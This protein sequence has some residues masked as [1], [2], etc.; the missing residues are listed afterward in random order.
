MLNGKETLFPKV[1]RTATLIGSKFD[2]TVARTGKK[3]G[4]AMNRVT[5]ESRRETRRK[6]GTKLPVQ[7]DTNR[8]KFKITD[9]EGAKHRQRSS[10][11]LYTVTSAKISKLVE[12]ERVEKR[13]D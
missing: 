8:S 1:D 7:S 6:L 13:T 12:R 11:I 5:Y 10:G 4:T 2:R 3:E 9:M